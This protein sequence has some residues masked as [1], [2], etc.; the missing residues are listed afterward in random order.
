[1]LTLLNK[2]FCLNNLQHP[3]LYQINKAFFSANLYFKLGISHFF[4]SLN[5]ILVLFNL[6]KFHKLCLYF[7]RYSIQIIIFK[8]ENLKK[9]NIPF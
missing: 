3:S 6:N 7:I 5:F 9:I 4:I 2:M 1:M 8:S